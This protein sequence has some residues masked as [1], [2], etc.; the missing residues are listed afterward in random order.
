MRN[1]ETLEYTGCFIKK[2]CVNYV[3]HFT[4]TLHKKDDLLDTLTLISEN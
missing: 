1:K 2:N 3:F 4:T